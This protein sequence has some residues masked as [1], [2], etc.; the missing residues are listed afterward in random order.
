[1]KTSHIEKFKLYINSFKII[2]IKLVCVNIRTYFIK[3]FYFP[4]QKVSEKRGIVLH[5]SNQLMFGLKN[6][7]CS[8][9]C[10]CMN[11]AGTDSFACSL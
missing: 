2:I 9:I 10:F 3:I 8:H 4:R 6:Q 5:F 11:S 7:L 1:M